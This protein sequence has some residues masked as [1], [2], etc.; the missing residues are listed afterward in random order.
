MAAPGDTL[1]LTGILAGPDSAGRLRLCLVDVLETPAY[2]GGGIVA[3]SSWARLLA[4]VPKTADYAVPYNLP[5]NG[6]PD[7]AGV[8]GECWVTLPKGKAAATAARRARL[9]ALA[10]ELRG[11]EV[12]ITVRPKRYAFA[13]AAA[14]NYGSEVAGTAL[15]FVGLEARATRPRGGR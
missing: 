7:D 14:H 6:A 15:L 1:E 5:L 10:A 11:K 12:T 13:S 3:D 4:A 8:R 2:E 9:E